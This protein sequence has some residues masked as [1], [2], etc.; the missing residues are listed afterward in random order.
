MGQ[1]DSKKMDENDDDLLLLNG[2]PA[3]RLADL[4]R[5]IHDGAAERN[6]GFRAPETSY[7]T[8]PFLVCILIC[9][10]NI[11]PLLA[12]RYLSLVMIKFTTQLG[13][14][15]GTKIHLYENG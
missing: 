15:C 14:Y 6:Y 2:T 10:L 4:S 12:F 11:G 3:I 5:P 13:F 7:G 1:F 8:V 9:Q